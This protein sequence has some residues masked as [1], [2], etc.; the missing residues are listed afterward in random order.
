MKDID[1]R[2]K[3]FLNIINRISLILMNN[4]KKTPQQMIESY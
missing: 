1:A 3:K 2:M 4:R